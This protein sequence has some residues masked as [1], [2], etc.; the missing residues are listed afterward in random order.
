MFQLLH[1]SALSKRVHHA[2]MLLPVPAWLHRTALKETVLS[3]VK[4]APG[5][6]LALHLGS[7]A[8]DKKNPEMLFGGAYKPDQKG[9]DDGQTPQHA[10][11]ARPMGLG[12]VLGMIAAVLELKSVSADS[13]LAI[14]FDSPPRP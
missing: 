14:S 12:V 6:R 2:L 5:D 1:E 7:I 8:L 13:P 11:P 9:P 4:V 3:G 10:C